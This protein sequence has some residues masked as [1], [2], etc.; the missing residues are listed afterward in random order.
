MLTTQIAVAGLIGNWLSFAQIERDGR[1][2]IEGASSP[3]QS[4]ERVPQP[5][6]RCSFAEA[7]EK[8]WMAST[9]EERDLLA[10]LAKVKTMTG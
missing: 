4:V 5:V 3:G 9:L 7:R 8:P 6:T 10:A 1:L 2:N